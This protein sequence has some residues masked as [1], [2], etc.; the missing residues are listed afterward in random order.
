ESG[1]PVIEWEPGPVDIAPEDLLGLD[2]GARRLR[3]DIIEWLKS[4]LSDG[5]VDSLDIEHRANLAGFSESTV[6][7]AKK[8]LKVVSRRHGKAWCWQLPDQDGQPTPPIKADNLDNLDHL[9]SNIV[10]I[11]KNGGG[12]LGDNLASKR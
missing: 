10:N 11:V 2:T 1:L 3:D 7:R 8:E 12:G 6:N 4:Q 5:P 9:D